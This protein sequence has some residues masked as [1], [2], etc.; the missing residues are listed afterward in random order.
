MD[1]LPDLDLPVWMNKGEPLTLAHATHTWWQR[2][3]E[4]ISFPLAQIDADTCD[5]EMLSLLAYQRDIERFEGE[6]LSLFRLRVKHAFPNAQDAGSVAGFERIFARLGIGE[7]QQLERQINYDWDVILL[8]INDEQLSRDNAL[9]MRIV[10]QYGRTC[11]RYFFDALNEKKTHTFSAEFECD[12]RF[13]SADLR[14]RPVAII[15]ERYEIWVAPTQRITIGVSV[16]PAEAEDRSFTAEPADKTLCSV[17][18]GS[19]SITMLGLDWGETEITLTANDGG[20][21]AVIAV[22]VVSAIKITFECNNPLSP[23]FFT[24]GTDD[25]LLAYGDENPAEEFEPHPTIKNAYILSRDIEIG[26]RYDITFYN[27]DEVTFSDATTGYAVN[28]ATKLHYL[29]GLRTDIDHIFYYHNGLEEVA[30]NAVYLPKVQSMVNAFHTTGIDYP[31]DDFLSGDMPDLVDIEGLF[32]A[33]ALRIAPEKF[34]KRSPNV[35]T[36]YRAFAY[37]HFEKTPAGIFDS[38][39]KKLNRADWLFYRATFPESDI[40]DIFSASA[41]PNIGNVEYLI[42]QVTTLRGEG[43]KIVDKMQTATITRMAL[44][45]ATGLSDYAD[46]PAGWRT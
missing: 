18:A 44:G 27:S 19:D 5:E 30:E 12:F 26:R 17:E 33:S 36:I 31:P 28:T 45:G 15:P 3:Y 46:I 24:P 29:V 42:Y 20:V 43:L 34:L 13:F 21:S 40:N 25:L 2:V 39:A 14:I 37:V 41:Y 16:L 10:R 7:L 38:C 32:R 8:R 4:W 9:M 35:N 1:K 6:S 22:H 23:V 11:R